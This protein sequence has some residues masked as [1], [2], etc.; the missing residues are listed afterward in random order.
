MSGKLRI[1]LV[2]SWYFGSVGCGGSEPESKTANDVP[3]EVFP[4]RRRVC[5]GDDEKL[6][7]VN[8]DGRANL[9]HV[10]RDGKEACAE[11][12]MNLDGRIDVTRLFDDNGQMVMEQHDF[13][14][15]GRLDQQVFYEAGAMIRKEVDTNFDKLVDTWI[16]CDGSFVKHLERDRKHTG[17]VD[18]WEDYVS[19][20]LV[21]IRYDA[22]NDGKPERWEQ[23]R[24]GH[25]YQVQLDA[26]LD[27]QP[28]DPIPQ[29]GDVGGPA[30][31][32]V[33][34]D[35]NP[36]P[37]IDS[38]SAQPAKALSDQSKSSTASQIAEDEAAAE[39]ASQ[40][41][42]ENEAKLPDPDAAKAGE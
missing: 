7:D 35:G 23:Y 41:V 22:N 33:S 39:K 4:L 17:F 12:D 28:D 11:I 9:R 5:E 38:P 10:Y 25:L 36:I 31:E 20:N 29:D 27:G 1:L 13:D 19:G 21:A 6:E 34:C 24:A 14:F 16:W 37:Q 8:G 15:D 42:D 40:P 2:I 32:A 30:V 3:R 18:T 26:N